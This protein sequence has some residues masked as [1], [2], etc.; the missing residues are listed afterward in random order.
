[1]SAKPP[2]IILQCHKADF[3]GLRSHLSSFATMHLDSKP[4]NRSVD[5]NWNIIA[6][7]IKEAIDNYIPHKMSKAKRHLLW[8]RP[9][10]Q[11]HDE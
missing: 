1:M 5:E 4:I 7:G 3:D 8:V 11:V 10:H 2:P 9:C 6:E